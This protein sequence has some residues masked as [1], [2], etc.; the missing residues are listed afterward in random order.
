[1]NKHYKTYY[2]SQGLPFNGNPQHVVVHNLCRTMMNYNEA[3]FNMAKNDMKQYIQQFYNCRFS[4]NNC[5]L[6]HKILTSI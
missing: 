1:M 6:N 5:R 2:A 4:D 3:S